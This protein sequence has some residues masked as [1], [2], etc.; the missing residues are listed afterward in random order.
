VIEVSGQKGENVTEGQDK[1]EAAGHCPATPPSYLAS[2]VTWCSLVF[3][4]HFLFFIANY[5]LNLVG[6]ENSGVN[7]QVTS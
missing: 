1:E 6:V 7:K 3:V 2:S 5:Q 4:H